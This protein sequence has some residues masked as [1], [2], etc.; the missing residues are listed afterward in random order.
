LQTAGRSV[1]S[2]EAALETID[3]F[4]FHSKSPRGQLIKKLPPPSLGDVEQ[5]HSLLDFSTQVVDA[6]E[7]VIRA[8][9][10]SFAEQGDRVAALYGAARVTDI[11]ALQLEFE[12][13]DADKLREASEFYDVHLTMP[14]LRILHF[15]ARDQARKKGTSARTSSFAEQEDRIA[16]VTGTYVLQSELD[17]GLYP[18]TYMLQEVPE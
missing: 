10:S 9:T 15:C 7:Q 5:D 14:D 2:K 17:L 8:R 18:E 3:T 1:I 12:Y 11:A 4:A 13:S 16:E 6:F